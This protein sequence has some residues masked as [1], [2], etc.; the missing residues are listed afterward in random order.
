MSEKILLAED[1]MRIAR[2]T[3]TYIEKAGYECVW[4]SNGRDALHVARR[5]KPDLIVLDLMLPEVDGWRVCETLRQES[6]IPIIMLTARITD[7]DIIRGLNIGADDYVTKPFKPDELIARIAAVLRRSQGKQRVPIETETLVVGD[8]Q[9]NTGTRECRVDGQLV[10]LTA[11]QFDLLVFFMKHPRQV[12]S[13]EQLID[14]VF[15]LEF[16]SYERAIDIHIRRLRTRIEKDPSNPQ[17]IQT[18]FGAGYRFCP[19]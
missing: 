7:A 8:I 5:E 15:G 3:Q 11:S 13:R 4:V 16:N 9:V 18:V 17:Y 19:E 2:W 14:S 12:F 6:D 1:E 10:H